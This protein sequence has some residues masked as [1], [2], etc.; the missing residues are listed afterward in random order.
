M[1]ASDRRKEKPV[2]YTGTI[3]TWYVVLYHCVLWCKLCICNVMVLCPSFFRY[4]G[5]S[6]FSCI[7]SHED[8]AG[9]V[10]RVFTLVPGGLIQGRNMEISE[11]IFSTQLRLFSPRTSVSVPLSKPRVDISRSFESSFSAVG[12]LTLYC[13]FETKKVQAAA[14]Q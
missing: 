4:C 12:S 5:L 6:S 8:I 1:A 13:D 10:D 7:L 11:K 2:M 14:V 3:Y 9:I